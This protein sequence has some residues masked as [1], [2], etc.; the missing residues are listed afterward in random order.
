[1]P[2]EYPNSYWKG[3]GKYQKE[4]EELYQKLVPKQGSADTLNGELIRAISILS[5]EFFKNNNANAYTANEYDSLPPLY[6]KLLNLIDYNVPGSTKSVYEIRKVI[7]ARAK[8]TKSTINLYNQLA[9][10]VISYVLTHEDKPL[11]S[12]YKRD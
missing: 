8:K 7:G 10:K 6:N 3:T 12:N 4:Y 11:P 9:D 1:M 5:H 2:T